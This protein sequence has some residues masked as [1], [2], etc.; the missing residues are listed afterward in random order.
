MIFLIMGLINL[1]RKSAMGL[2]TSADTVATVA[3][4]AVVVAASKGGKYFAAA[5]AI[6]F[7]GWTSSTHFP[8]CRI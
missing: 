6:L 5:S 1:S 8:L 3:I 2:A 4:A 7:S